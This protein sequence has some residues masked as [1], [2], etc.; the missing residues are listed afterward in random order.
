M[1]DDGAEV[2]EHKDRLLRI[3]FLAG[4]IMDAGA[5]L[6]MLSPRV[7]RLLWGIHDTPAS[8]RLA[9]SCGA[10]LMLGWTCLLI[11]AD[12]RPLERRGVLILTAFPVVAGLFISGVYA[13]VAHLIEFR[14]LL[15]MFVIQ[16]LVGT[17]FLVAYIRSSGASGEP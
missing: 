11:W 2:L 1:E 10:S 5:L 9:M 15:P 8:Y 14:H 6:P 4:A 13:V 16:I 12:R 7:A 17:L 3:A